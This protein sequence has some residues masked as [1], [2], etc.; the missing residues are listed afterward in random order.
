[1][2]FPTSE[3]FCLWGGMQFVDDGARA[4]GNDNGNDNDND[5]GSR[6]FASTR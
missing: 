1:M 6:L 5:N 4:T 3:G 2:V